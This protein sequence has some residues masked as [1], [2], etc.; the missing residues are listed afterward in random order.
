MER[1]G[2]NVQCPR[3]TFV[4]R[5]GSLAEPYQRRTTV[6]GEALRGAVRRITRG[7]REDGGE[8][9]TRERKTPESSHR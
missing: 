1:E 6:L 4:A 2:V 5:L 7:P 8:R 9:P 3:R